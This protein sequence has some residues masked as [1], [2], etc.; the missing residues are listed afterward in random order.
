MPRP[1]NY[2]ATSLLVPLLLLAAPPASGWRA[3]PLPQAAPIRLRAHRARLPMC[4]AGAETASAATISLLAGMA[5][6]AIG[7]GVAYPLDTIKTKMQAYR[8]GGPV[9]TAL[10]IIEKEGISGFYGGVSSTMA[11]QAL[12]KGVLF[13][14][15][16]VVQTALRGATG[17]APL[18]L[19]SLALAAGISGA[20]ASI[21]ATPVERVKVRM[22]ATVPLHRPTAVRGS[23]SYRPLLPHSPARW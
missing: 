8:T 6:G 19:S 23:A 7:V 15:Y 17:G 2:P 4:V 21:V 1:T 13:F 16:G 9:E 12:I 22:L 20:I 14:T 5:S 3:P 18:S 10:A 11:G